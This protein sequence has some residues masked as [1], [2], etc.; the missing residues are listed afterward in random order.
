MLLSLITLVLPALATAN[1][2]I[3]FNDQTT[4]LDN[5][6]DGVKVPVQL[7]V[8]SRCP[9][10]LLCEATFNGVLEKVWDKVN[11]SLVYVAKFN[12]SDPEFG[13][14]CLHGKEECAGNVQQLCVAKYATPEQWWS[15]VQCQNFGGREAIGSPEVALRCASVAQIDW[16]TSGAGQCAGL[17]GS[18]KAPEGVKLM[19][20]SV[21]LGQTLGITKSCTILISARKVCVHDVTWKECE[22]GHTVNDFVRQIDEEYEKL[23]SLVD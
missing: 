12:K 7:G 17:D 2:R 20:E 10:A 13:M 14:T 16:E 9:D 21:K 15:F 19:H 11:L 4:K 18:G 5:P 23:N 8:M 22:G 6:F 3:V 1:P